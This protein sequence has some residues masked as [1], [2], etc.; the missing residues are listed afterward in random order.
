MHHVKE[1]NCIIKLGGTQVNNL[2]FAADI[3]LIDEDSKSLQ[4]QLEKTRAVAEQTGLI[5]NIGKTQTVVFDD[6]KIGQRIQTGGKNIENVDKFQYLGTLIIWDNNCSQETRRQIGKAVGTVAF[7]RHVWNNKK[8]TI[9]NKLRILIVCVFSVLLYTLE[10][11]T[12][13]KIDKKK[14]LTLEMRCYRRILRISWKNMVKTERHT[15][16]NSKRR[17]NHRY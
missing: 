13:K 16:D 15:K 11:W 6:R 10:T 14:L 12:L 5:V 4:E 2:T 9:Q 8:L 7:M 3:D 17:N 1:S